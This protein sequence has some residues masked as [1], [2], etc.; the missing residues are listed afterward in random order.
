[1]CTESNQNIFTL[2]KSGN[3]GYSLFAG[4]FYLS[5]EPDGRVF[6]SKQDDQKKTSFIPE[7]QSSSYSHL[8]QMQS[9][10]PSSVVNM[11]DYGNVLK[12]KTCTGKYF[13]YNDKG[14]PVSADDD[15][16][17]VFTVERK[18][19]SFQF[20]NPKGVYMLTTQ[21]NNAFTVTKTKD[22]DYTLFSGEHFLGVSLDNRVLIYKQD[23]GKETRFHPLLVK[24]QSNPLV[25]GNSVTIKTN[26][27]TYFYYDE[28]G[29]PTTGVYNN[30]AVFKIGN[31]LFF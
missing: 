4:Q 26:N 10:N 9:T 1:M 6:L 14:S 23:T 24:Q 11:L 18:G 5:I 17:S 30:N 21:G 25:N 7:F 20:R 2:S 27:G 22:G 3:A 19:N 29:S 15:V 16:N 28:N 8:S 13:Y 12:F 31:F